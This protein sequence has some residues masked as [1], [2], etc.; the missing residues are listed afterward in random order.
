MADLTNSP[1]NRA[2]GLS[3]RLSV[4]QRDATNTLRRSGNDHTLHSSFALDAA[5]GKET[6]ARVSLFPQNHSQRQLER[7]TLQNHEHQPAGR[8]REPIKQ[9][10]EAHAKRSEPDDDVE[11][12]AR[13]GQD[14]RAHSQKI[15][16]TE[17]PVT[18]EY[19]EQALFLSAALQE[20][21][22]EPVISLADDAGNAALLHEAELTSQNSDLAAGFMH[23]NLIDDAPPT[24]HH[25]KDAVETDAASAE[26]LA[27]A[28]AAESTSKAPQE[29][30]APVLDRQ[31]TQQ[32]FSA[33]HAAEATQM[34]QEHVANANQ[35]QQARLE[36][37]ATD[38]QA[39][40]EAQQLSDEQNHAEMSQ[41]DARKQFQQTLN[42]TVKNIMLDARASSSMMHQ[43]ANNNLAATEAPVTEQFVPPGGEL[44]THGRQSQFDAATFK[45]SPVNQN[46][47]DNTAAFAQRLSHGAL[48]EQ[49]SFEL[50]SLGAQRDRI[51]I[52]LRPQ[53]LGRV[54]IK[55]DI[56]S[57]GRAEVVFASERADI[58]DML[59][60]DAKYLVKLLEQSGLDVHENDLV[61]QHQDTDQQEQKQQNPAQQDRQDPLPNDHDT[62]WWHNTTQR[63]M[64][65]ESLKIQETMSPKTVRFGTTWYE[66]V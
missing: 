33:A 19:E 52:Q 53:E 26:P 9:K 5:K 49:M 54:D 51:E 25:Y 20:S 55:F 7:R 59:K 2:H 3:D 34:A 30:A 31:F 48:R 27:Q 32:V 13:K 42:P 15:A 43:A 18:Q 16:S 28:L 8:E 14:P 10:E 24:S 47:V 64:D 12:K 61:F 17:T 29:G 22:N 6:P 44:Q 41:E 45:T 4:S 40:L 62:P 35:K 23:L 46:Q 58:N 66:L 36:S 56:A 39:K 60:Q 11:T 57:D 63:T 1:I 65:L 38:I 50:R 37:E 21:L